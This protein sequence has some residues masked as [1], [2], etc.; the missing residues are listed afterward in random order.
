MCSFSLRAGK[1]SGSASSSPISVSA[2]AGSTPSSTMI[3]S[4]GTM[5]LGKTANPNRALTAA[6]E[7]ASE[8]QT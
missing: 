7:P 8:P 5:S 4:S 3:R 6:S 2:I 1:D